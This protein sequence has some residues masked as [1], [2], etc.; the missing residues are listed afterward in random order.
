MPGGTLKRLPS[1]PLRTMRHSRRNS[2]TRP[3]GL[4]SS[5][6]H[7]GVGCRGPSSDILI[8]CAH[9]D[10]INLLFS[11]LLCFIIARHPSRDG[12]KGMKDTTGLLS[13]HTS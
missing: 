6:S 7:R 11:H 2:R 10:H 8:N 5:L 12:R 4:R 9:D 1:S 13:K 3:P